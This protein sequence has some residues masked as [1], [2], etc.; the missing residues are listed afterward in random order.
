MSRGRHTPRNLITVPPGWYL[1]VQILRGDNGQGPSS[2]ETEILKDLRQEFMDLEYG[3]GSD[4]EAHGNDNPLITP[5]VKLVDAIRRIADAG[6]A[7]NLT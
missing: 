5:L 6:E 1:S 2:A 7:K 4:P 3:P